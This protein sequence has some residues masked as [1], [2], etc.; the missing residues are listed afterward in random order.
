M[1]PAARDCRRVAWCPARPPAS[2]PS[3][4]QKAVSARA[5]CAPRRT[6]PDLG[7][8]W[9]DP[10]QE[11]PEPWRPGTVGI[12]GGWESGMVET[13]VGAPRRIGTPGWGGDAGGAVKTPRWWRL[14]SDG[15]WG[16]LVPRRPTTSCRLRCPARFLLVACLA[17]GGGVS[18]AWQPQAPLYPAWLSNR[19]AVRRGGGRRPREEPLPST[20][21]FECIID[22]LPRLG[23]PSTSKQLG[24][25]KGW[26]ARKAGTSPGRAARG[27][28]GEGA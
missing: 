4:P 8:T 12:R 7:G 26:H 6:H 13:G 18:R 3:V 2:A 11:T 22:E 15:G 23:A 16:L 9:R 5:L 24:D 25:R 28:S 14:Q 27:R 10:R 17:L 19:R 20:K 21:C 1:T